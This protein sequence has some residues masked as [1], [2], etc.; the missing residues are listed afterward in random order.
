MVVV[1]DEFDL[2]HR[3]ETQ[4]KKV[5]LFFILMSFIYH[6]VV[7]E[8]TL[9]K[10]SPLPSY[11]LWVIVAVISWIIG[12]SV[13]SFSKILF[14]IIGSF[15]VAGVVSYFLMSY[16]IREGVTGLVQ[17]ITLK[18]ISISLLTIFVLSSVCALFGYMFRSR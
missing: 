18:M 15:V 11:L 7:F 17:I 9:G 12:L 16:Y 2:T 1:V 8:L 14:I 4:M 5:L 6:A 3:G 13:Q 10:F